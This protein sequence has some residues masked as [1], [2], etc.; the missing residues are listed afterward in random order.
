MHYS[1]VRLCTA[2]SLSL[3]FSTDWPSIHYKSGT[4]G[5]VCEGKSE[6]V[7]YLIDEAENPGKGANRTVS[8][9]YG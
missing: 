6:Q 5:V 8:L 1:F 9:I 4:V 7:N 2:S 3:Q